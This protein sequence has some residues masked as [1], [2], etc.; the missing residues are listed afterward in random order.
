M[1]AE[2]SDSLY[3]LTYST[4]N[5]NIDSGKGFISHIKLVPD[6]GVL[7]RLIAQHKAPNNVFTVNIDSIKINA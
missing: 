2:A 3:H 6:P 1:L 7:K 4:F 5:L